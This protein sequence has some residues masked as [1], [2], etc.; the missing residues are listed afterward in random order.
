MKVA[1]DCIEI[2]AAIEKFSYLLE[3]VGRLPAGI[4]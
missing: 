2:D 1:I 3:L 4:L